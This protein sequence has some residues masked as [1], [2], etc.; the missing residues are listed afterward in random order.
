[1]R[2]GCV[3]DPR[4]HWKVENGWHSSLRSRRCFWYEVPPHH[5]AFDVPFVWLMRSHLISSFFLYEVPPSF[6][7]SWAWV[8]WW[9]RPTV[10]S[11]FDLGCSLLFLA[12]IFSR[13]NLEKLWVK[14]NETPHWFL[15]IKIWTIQNTV[16]LYTP[17]V[18]LQSDLILPLDWSS[19]CYY[20]KEREGEHNLVTWLLLEKP[21][22][23]EIQL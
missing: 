10:S 8:W 2:L 5:S 21:E 3:E 17:K 9:I 6:P 14:R 23:L 22:S 12:H 4:S 11:F 7:V 13:F 18:L 16:S 20:Y 1:M 15:Q 19:T